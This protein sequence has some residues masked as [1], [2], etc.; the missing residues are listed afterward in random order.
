[1]DPRG[2][3]ESKGINPDKPAIDLSAEDALTYI[4]EEAADLELELD[5]SRLTTNELLT[6]ISSY[7]AN[8]ILFHPENGHQVR[9]TL[10]ENF[11]MLKKCG[12]KDEDYARFQFA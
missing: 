11:E 8:V 3:L 2:L 4:L 10:Q 7:G 6:L 12:L 1:M 5:L 9:A